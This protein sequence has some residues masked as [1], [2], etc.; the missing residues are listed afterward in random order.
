MDERL[1]LT[2]VQNFQVVSNVDVEGY[3]AGRDSRPG[4]VVM[5][6]HFKPWG[7][8]QKDGDEAVIGMGLGFRDSLR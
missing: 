2:I 6:H 3:G 1:E 5:V 7:A 4:D 8:L